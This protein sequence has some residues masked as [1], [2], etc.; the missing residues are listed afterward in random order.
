MR[1]FKVHAIF[2]YKKTGL[3]LQFLDFNV[4]KRDLYERAGNK[5]MLNATGE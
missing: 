4:R 1:I 5:P 3:L 2:A